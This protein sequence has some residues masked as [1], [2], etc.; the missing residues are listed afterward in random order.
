MLSRVAN[1]LFW[2]TRYLERAENTARFLGVTDSYARELQGVSRAAAEACWGVAVEHL[3]LDEGLAADASS[4]PRLIFDVELP[5]SV[6]A[7]VTMARENARSIRDAIASE[8]WEGLNVLYLRLQGEAGDATSTTA[9]QA[10]LVQVQET[11]HLLQGLRDNVMV[12]SD[13]WHFLRIGRFLERADHTLRIQDRMFRHP[14]LTAAAA[15]G[16]EIDTLHLAAALRMAAAFEAFSR[17]A[18]TLG[19]ERVL[20]FL[21][22]DARF[23]R[24]VEF[25]IQEL[26]RSLHALSR[27]PEDIY[28]NEAE[29]LCGRLVAELRFASIEEI[30]GQGLPETFDRVLRTVGAIGRAISEEYFT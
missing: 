26:E 21:L 29:Q 8:M 25:C 18:P 11:S 19:T 15:G 10:L 7:C 14:A 16:Q 24:S 2:L 12:R 22:L 27:T 1:S 30:I 20:E 3:A 9:Q 17:T 4:L 13:E 5:G 23:P 28:T 6:L